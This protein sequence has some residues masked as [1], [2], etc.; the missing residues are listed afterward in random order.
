M[1]S[2]SFR[3]RMNMTIDPPRTTRSRVVGW[4]CRVARPS[5]FVRSSCGAVI[6]PSGTPVTRTVASRIVAGPRTVVGGERLPSRA[7]P[8]IVGGSVLAGATWACASARPATAASAVTAD[9]I[10]ATAS[11]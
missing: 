2:P 9:A 10:A 1:L 8:V 11:S 5:A 6:H 7:V 3:A 4:S